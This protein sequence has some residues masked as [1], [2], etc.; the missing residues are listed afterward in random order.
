[1]LIVL[2]LVVGH[3]QLGY[4]FASL[5]VRAVAFA[6]AQMLMTFMS[7]P[8]ADAKYEMLSVT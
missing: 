8:Y 5:P 7:S 6:K 4:L 2:T 3:D 1:M